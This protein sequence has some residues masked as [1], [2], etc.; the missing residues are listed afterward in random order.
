MSDP[1]PR[2]PDP[3]LSRRK[4]LASGAAG[5]AGLYGLRAS[6]A[7]A[8]TAADSVT[9]ASYEENAGIPALAADTKLFTKKYG[10]DVKTH[11]FAHGP[12][13]EQINSYLQ[14]HPDDVFTWFAGYRMQFFA[15][16]GLA[17]PIDDVWK[18]LLTPQMP[19]AFKAASTGL[20]GHQ[21]FVP[22]KNYP[23]AV[24]YRKSLWKEKG[25]AAPRTWAQL[26]AL[27]KKM[28][29]D[30]LTPIAFTDKDGWPPMGTFDI[31]NMRINGYEY[32]VRLMAGKQS[33]D[34]P[35]VK[36]V[37][38]KW[39]ELFPY[40]SEGA[41]G[42]SW[43]DGAAQLEN[44][45]AGMFFLGGFLTGAMKPANAKDI[46]F[47]PFPMINPKWGQDS[48]DAPIDGYMISRHPKNIDGAK[49]LVGFLGTAPAIDAYLKINSGN[50]GS[51]K[52]TNTS[53]YSPL[54]KKEA[55]LI[56]ATK[57][58]AQYMDRD[59]RPDFASTVMIPSL[60]SFINDPG[61][62]DK[63]VQSIE[64]QKKAIFGA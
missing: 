62:V 7:G 49:K 27:A 47:F 8:A 43:Q 32:H 17:T 52:H 56:A 35:Q 4:L 57:H 16:K 13:Q 29:D 36:A 28:K 6:R 38:N 50:L 23:W 41:L 9:L 1:I 26:I 2:S 48:I 11:T 39:R 12:F 53:K 25:Y 63:L 42:L 60:Q 46:D 22:N 31:I 21:Y 37:F 45:Q 34:S 5:A 55:K 30:G 44:K 19:A 61:N 15:A 20:D 33:W 18:N 59:T 58:I 14:G 10:I 40:Y 24:Y 64:K 54:Q 51:N 3:V